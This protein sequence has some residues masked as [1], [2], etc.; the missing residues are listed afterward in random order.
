M[1]G[2]EKNVWKATAKAAMKTLEFKILQ[3]RYRRFI[4]QYGPG[5][6]VP[7]PYQ[8]YFLKDSAANTYLKSVTKNL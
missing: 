1:P 6:Q 3:R 5:L 8:T 2:E 4:D 7:I